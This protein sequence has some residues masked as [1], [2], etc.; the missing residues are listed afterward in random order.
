MKKPLVIGIGN[1]FRGDDGAGLAAADL[2]RQSLGPAV[3]VFSWNGDAWDL[4]QA[5]EGRDRVFLI[6]AVSTDSSQI[7]HLHR[8]LANEEEIPGRFFHYSTHVLDLSQVIALARAMGK[9][10]KHMIFY[11][12]EGKEFHLENEMSE[13]LRK[14][15]SAVTNRIENDIRNEL[16]K[17][18][19]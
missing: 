4:M 10:P 14:S 6:D 1:K 19:D 3:E 12:I 16:R 18:S 5:W 2:L 9:L 13:K 7:G 8:Y 11:G 15:L 17:I